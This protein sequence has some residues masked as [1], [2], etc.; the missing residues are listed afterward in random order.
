M[1]VSPLAQRLFAALAAPSQHAR[2][3][4]VTAP[5]PGLVVE[6]FTGSESVCAPY[7]F[8]ID[9][10][11]TSAF[12]DLDTVLGQP[13]ALHLAT[14]DGTP[15]TWRGLCTEAMAL[16]SDGGLARYRL[17][18]EPWAALLRLRR[19]TLIFQDLDVRG[20]I[21]RVFA[22]YP[23]AAARFE[24]TRSLPVYPITT[25]YRETD[26]DFVTR[27]LAQAGLAWR[28]EAAPAVATRT[29]V[30]RTAIRHSIPG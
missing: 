21:E 10:L 22:D 30:G 4:R 29:T 24:L 20:V 14:A 1:E 28:F 3:I 26:F 5:V 13:L 27:L 15:R 16:G 12:L 8:E 6:R 9:C 2:L 23:Q 19:N 25:Q 17:V 11:S 18:L 7:R